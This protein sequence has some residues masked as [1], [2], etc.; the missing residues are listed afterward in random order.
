MPAFWDPS[1]TLS[2]LLNYKA[3]ARRARATAGLSKYLLVV[4]IPHWCQ[5]NLLNSFVQRL[6]NNLD[7]HFGTLF[8][9][10]SIMLC[11]KK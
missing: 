3:V 4:N 9:I 1:L 6:S 5:S 11:L 8:D 2:D 10:V 7:C